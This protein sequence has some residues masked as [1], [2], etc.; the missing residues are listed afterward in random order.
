MKNP[1][2]LND[3]PHEYILV[4]YY[5]DENGKRKKKLDARTIGK[6]F[7]L[8]QV[9]HLKKRG[10]D[11]AR[12]MYLNQSKYVVVDIDTDD[13]SI[14]QLFQDTGIESIW[15]KGNTKGFHVYM[16]IQGNKEAILKKT[17]VNCGRHCEMDFLG[18]C[19]LEV[20]DKEWYGAEEPAYLNGE[21]FGKCFKKELFMDKERTIQPTEGSP[22][23]SSEQLKKI[24]DLISAEYCEDF[25]KW[26]SIILAMKK[27]GFTEQEAI[28]FS[29]K[30]G[31]KHRFERTKIWEQYDNLCI[32]PTEGT[33][34]Y[35]AKLSNKD[36][37]L[38]LT[39]NT[40]I[41]VNDI[42][43]GA[44]FVAERIHTTLKS[45]IVFCD[46]KW[47]VCNKKT[48]LW[49]QVKSPTYQVI[50]EI[51][52]RL[53]QAL[54]V[55]AEVLEATTDNEENKSTRDQLIE[56]QKQF[57]KFY[58]KCDSC[59]FTSQITTHLSHLL[60]DD[61]FINKL[62]AN[63][64][65]IAYQNGILDLKTMS[66]IKDIKRDYLLTKTL[67]FDYE[68]PSN[69]D[70][71][72]V[73][74]VIFKICNCNKEHLEYYLQVLGHAMTGEA[75]LEKAMYFCIGIG[76]DNGK[77]LIF[78]ALLQIM[79]NYVYKIERKTFEDGYS[80]PHKHLTKTRGKRI[81]FLEE[82]SAKKQN[83]E[84]IKDIAD[85]KT[86]TNE[87][88]FG[89]EENIPV[90]FKQFILGNVNPNMEAD[91]GVANRFRQL[92]FNSN[93]GKKNTV[94]DYENLSFVQDKFLSDKLVGQ[95]KHALIYLLFQYSTKYYSLDRIEMP[96]E[97]KEATEETLND[98]DAF[99]SFFNDNFIID[100]D[101][102]C[103]KKEMISLT[104]KPLR[105]LNSE[106]MRIGKYKYDKGIRCGTDRGGWIGFKVAPSPCLLD[107]DELS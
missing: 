103:G 78:D 41:Q 6:G 98:C 95:Y 1:A 9:K 22:P 84:M 4:D 72:F 15:V 104:K 57:L 38:K 39:G 5:Q 47:W 20:I 10:Q 80:K 24:M 53:D 83:I 21:Q 48:Q 40:L 50:C 91:G 51:H 26:R 82:L 77:T 13:Y 11:I 101:G 73:R 85:G 25:D 89:T 75:H 34:R 64:N 107:N 67:P 2:F 76:G 8:Q 65:T 68:K 31:K 94:D 35:Y 105:E 55:T 70:I 27:C 62:D 7:T 54:K 14:E 43:K 37:Y 93:F 19:V 28:A 102:K 33:L 29:A 36:A 58:D 69:E 61:E 12:Y 3:I 59:G 46:K 99:Q 49:E 30:G 66:F 42:E 18:K 92:S 52:R 32:S 87:V 71:Q 56:K 79:P 96:E 16:E 63:I 17:K 44:R 74:D 88:M 97:F 86:I 106:L 100:P 45:C 60:T 23:T 90:Y 81:V